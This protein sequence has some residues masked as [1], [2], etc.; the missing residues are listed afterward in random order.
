M[1]IILNL[2]KSQSGFLPS[3]L[4]QFQGLCLWTVD[5][6]TFSDTHL[7]WHVQWQELLIIVSRFLK[8]FDISADRKISERNIKLSRQKNTSFQR[9]RTQEPYFSWQVN[10]LPI[11]LLYMLPCVLG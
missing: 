10:T 2:V 1:A 3:A 5:G 9:E 6:N 11:T 4:F 8:Q 7:I